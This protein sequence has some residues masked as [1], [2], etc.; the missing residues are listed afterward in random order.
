MRLQLCSVPEAI[1]RRDGTGCRL[2][3]AEIDDAAEITAVDCRRDRAAK[4]LRA[5]PRFLVLEERRVGI[6]VEPHHLG[7]ERSAC[8]VS[9]RWRLSGPAIKGPGLHGVA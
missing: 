6:L 3:V 7:F 1:R 4:I 9:L 5:E 2:R 8:I